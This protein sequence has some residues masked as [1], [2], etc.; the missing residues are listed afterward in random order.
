MSPAELPEE[1][2]FVIGRVSEVRHQGANVDLLEYPGQ[3]GFVHISEVASGWVKYIRDFIREGQMVVAKVTRVKRKRHI[4]D[5]SVRQ[6]SGHRKQARIREWKNEQRATKLIELV[7]GEAKLEPAALLEEVSA[8]FRENYGTLYGAFEAAVMEQDDFT[9]AY[10]GKWVKPFLATAEANITLPFVT[11]EGRLTLSSW[12]PDGV[13]HLKRALTAPAA[14]EE[15]TTLEISSD[16]APDYRIR[17]RAPD[18]KQAER[19]LKA[20]TDVVLKAFKPSGG[21]A[22]FERL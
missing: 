17:V 16:G 5:M 2:E 6:V 12:A 20:A 21:E 14:Q 1:G 19:E 15:E 18:F 11:I 10:K 4:V 8:S 9:K 13:E 7:A 3:K 22:S